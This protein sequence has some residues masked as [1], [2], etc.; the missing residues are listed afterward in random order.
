M[1]G[2]GRL[3]EQA[4]TEAHRRPHRLERVG[5]KFLRHQS[6]LGARR[7]VVAHDIVPVGEHGA[8]AGVDDAADDADQRGLAGAVGSEQGKDLAATDVEVD[9][10]ERHLAGRVGLAHVADRN[11][12]LHAWSFHFPKGRSAHRNRRAAPGRVPWVLSPSRPERA[13]RRGFGRGSSAPAGPAARA[14]LPMPPAAPRRRPAPSCASQVSSRPATKPWCTAVMVKLM[15]AD[16]TVTISGT[17]ASWAWRGVSM[18][19]S[20]NGG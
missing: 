9:L 16:I 13:H 20:R 11:D 4:A 18:G 14:P 10:L 5:R 3:A 2:I 15:T 12:R 8:G 17:N 6:D 1:R 19:A 7:A